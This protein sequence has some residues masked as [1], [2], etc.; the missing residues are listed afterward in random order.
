MKRL[1]TEK[2]EQALRLCHHDFDGFSQAEAAKQ[3]NISQSALNQLLIRVK[4]VMPQY[5]P[6]LTKLEYKCYNLYMNEGWNVKTIAEHQLQ[7]EDAICKA[8]QRAYKKGMWRPKAHGRI[9]SYDELQERYINIEDG[10]TTDD[11][12]L[13]FHVKQKF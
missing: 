7:T 6:I 8:L 9:Q 1:I 3:M 12:W 5:F 11:N 13:D 4:K 10:E 2:Q